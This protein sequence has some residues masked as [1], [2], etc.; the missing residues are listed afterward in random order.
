MISNKYCVLLIALASG[1]SAQFSNYSLSAAET[2][3]GTFNRNWCP[4]LAWNP[5]PNTKC[6]SECYGE[7]GR[8]G[9]SWCYTKNDKKQWGAPC[10]KCYPENKEWSLVAEK[11]ECSGA[12]AYIGWVSTLE[13][14]AKKCM[15]SS[16]FIYGTNDFGSNK[17]GK[18][19]W[20]KCYCETA[21]SAVNTCNQINHSGYRLY[22]YK[23][24]DNVC[25]GN[26]QEG[27]K[28]PPAGTK[29]VS[30]C[31]HKHGYWGASYCYTDE[32]Q[33]QWGAECVAC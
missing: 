25:T 3:S 32:E 26:Y 30:R 11:K 9:D 2:C 1:I 13:E 18:D 19:K 27:G 28:R 24:A 14:C 8:W 6:T 21:A 22:Q 12:E 31:V 10:E 4:Y 33:K 20:C 16:M 15:W 23:I 7:K 5:P 17:C 29:C